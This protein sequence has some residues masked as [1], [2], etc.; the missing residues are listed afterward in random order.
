MDADSVMSELEALGTPRTKKSYLSR[1]VTESLSGAAT[2][3]MKPLK[4][5]IGVD[6]AHADE[7]WDTGNYDAMYLA[8]MV[9]HVAAMSEADFEWWIDGAFRHTRC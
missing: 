4:K 8:G 3:A 1:G 9:A 7:L 5:Q 2:G 6:R